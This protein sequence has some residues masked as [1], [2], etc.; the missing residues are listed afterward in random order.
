MNVKFE[1][2]A[3]HKNLARKIFRNT[4]D[5]GSVQNTRYTLIAKQLSVRLLIL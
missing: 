2:F 5:Y 3:F 1:K 4:V